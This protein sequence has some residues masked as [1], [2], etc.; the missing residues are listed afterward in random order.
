M[1]EISNRH[2]SCSRAS[3]GIFSGI[4]AYVELR[5]RLDAAKENASTAKQAGAAIPIQ[6]APSAQV[7]IRQERPGAGP[8]KPERGL[9]VPLLIGVIVVMGLAAGAAYW[10]LRPAPAVPMGV[11]ELNATPFAEVVSVT[12]EK[13]KVIPL[14][15]GDHWTP[16]RLD[17]IPAGIYAVS[18]KGADGSTQSQQCDVAQSAQV[19]SIELKP[20]DDTAIEEIIGGA[21]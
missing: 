16:L 13:G 9:L 11:L 17:D 6:Q 14:P 19:C 20:I 10:F 4:R 5:A 15:A 21:K 7:A 12:S 8:S 2:Y 18:F 1:S 3:R